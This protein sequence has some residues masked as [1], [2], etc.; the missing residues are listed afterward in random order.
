VA[1]AHPTGFEKLAAQG[2]DVSRV[3]AATGHP[4][5]F[6][7]AGRNT[8]QILLSIV[9]FTVRGVINCAR[10]GSHMADRISQDM[11]K[12]ALGPYSLLWLP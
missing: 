12:R 5:K 8:M 7:A 1:E 10:L 9:I 4:A 6:L 3:A 2:R 11:L